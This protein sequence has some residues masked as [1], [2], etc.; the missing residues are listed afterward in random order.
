MRVRIYNTFLRYVIKIDKTRVIYTV[1]R[2]SYYVYRNFDVWNIV[3]FYSIRWDVSINAN[4]IAFLLF[5]RH[6]IVF[7]F[8]AKHPT[9]RTT[10]RHNFAEKP[11]VPI[12]ACVFHSSYLLLV[13]YTD[14]T[15]VRRRRNSTPRVRLK[16]IK[17][18]LFVRKKTMCKLVILPRHVQS[19]RLSSFLSVIKTDFGFKF[20]CLKIYH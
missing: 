11:K 14:C 9:H 2:N 6:L 18:R 15:F 17:T 13:R 12:I 19:Y 10:L 16:E 1:G 3:N 8:D 7:F 5:G 20:V 4:Y